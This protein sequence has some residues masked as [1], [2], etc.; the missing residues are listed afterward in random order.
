MDDFNSDLRDDELPDESDCDADD[1][2]H[3]FDLEP[4]IFCGKGIYEDAE[5]CHHCG[6]YVGPEVKNRRSMWLIL[7]MIAVAI[8]LLAGVLLA[9]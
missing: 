1:S 4:C 3:S 5:I 6:S 7:V 2:S 8:A 9:R